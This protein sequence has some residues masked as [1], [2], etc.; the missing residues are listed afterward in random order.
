MQ[1]ERGE[2]EKDEKGRREAE[3][4]KE[5]AEIVVRATPLTTNQ[6]DSHTS[7]THLASNSRR[8]VACGQTNTAPKLKFPLTSASTYQGPSHSLRTLWTIY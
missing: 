8:D 3:A 6:L 1:N 5:A 4:E 2:E 7:C